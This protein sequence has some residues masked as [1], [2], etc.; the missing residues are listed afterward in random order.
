MITFLWLSSSSILQL[1]L[2]KLS[3]TAHS[4]T[5]ASRAVDVV[6]PLRSSP[7][8]KA[9][10]DFNDVPFSCP[11]ARRV[12]P[13]PTT[14]NEKLALVIGDE[15]VVLYSFSSTP[16]SPI[17]S[18]VSSSP[19]IAT[20]PRASASRR[21]PQDEM[22]S[23]AGKKRKSSTTSRTMGANGED[24]W[25]VRPVWRLRQGLGTVLAWVQKCLV[26][27]KLK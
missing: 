9:D 6:S 26:D 10:T 27:Q 19:S 4:F 23:S 1:Q 13:I 17:S 14:G 8:I 21:S 12:I 2:R 22:V 25:T 15:H 3:L 7:E 20:S 18:R 24:K 11:A 16:R 5:E